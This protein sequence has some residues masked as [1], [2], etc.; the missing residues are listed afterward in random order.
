MKHIEPRGNERSDG[1]LAFHAHR[2][3]MTLQARVVPREE[4]ARE[5]GD[6]DVPTPQLVEELPV[7][8]CHKAVEPAQLVRM[9]DPVEHELSIVPV[10]A[11]EHDEAPALHAFRLAHE[12]R[13]VRLRIGQ[14]WQLTGARL[15]PR[16]AVDVGLCPLLPAPATW[17]VLAHVPQVALARPARPVPAR[18]IVR[19]DPRHTI[20]GLTAHSGVAHLAV[21]RQASW[22]AQVVLERWIEVRAQ[23]TCHGSDGQRGGQEAA[24][25]GAH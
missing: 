12:R 11:R 4:Q 13:V 5:V 2:L 7:H 20:G 3:D 15:H 19:R 16:L 14:V 10:A 25:A 1:Q 8:G 21:S 17:S 23:L 22:R 18:D 6:R 9:L 24:C